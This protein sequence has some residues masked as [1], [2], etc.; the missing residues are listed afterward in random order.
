MSVYYYD[1][2][3]VTDFRRIFNNS[4]ISIVPPENVFDL[5][6]FLD[7]DKVRFPLVSLNRV[8]W[9][10]SNNWNHYALHE[11]VSESI[12]Y[13]A[14]DNEPKLIMKLQAMPISINYQLD[15]WTKTL[16]ENDN[17]LRELMFYYRINPTLQVKIPYGI[18]SFHK[19]NVFFETD[20]T[21]NSD[22]PDHGNRGRYFRQ[23]IGMY[24]DDAYL[25]S[26]RDAKPT[27]IEGIDLFAKN[28]NTG[29]EDKETVNVDSSRLHKLNEEVIVNDKNL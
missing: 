22:I 15:V 3:L 8:G 29:Y 14:D 11:G 6:A 7:N 27:F 24:V 28:N 23:T 26:R 9:A 5:T 16:Q 2:A 12:F 17:I 21:D 4:K 18:D 13:G 19:F 20:V 10:L 25:F 1:E